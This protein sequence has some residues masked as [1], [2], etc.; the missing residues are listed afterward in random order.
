M[1]P[2]RS[3]LA[4]LSILLVGSCVC[5]GQSTNASIYGTVVDATGAVVTK[6]IVVATNTRTGIALSTMS[7]ESGVYIFGSL[8][9][10]EYTVSA[11][12]AGFRKAVSQQFQLA[13]SARI[14][15]D[16]KLEVG[17]ATES[18]TAESSSSLLETVNTSVSNVVSLR[19]V[20]DLPLTPWW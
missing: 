18:V 9:P 5:S 2:R 13:V 12:A 1:N 15:V 19:R 4:I 8:Q 6:S 14:T 11:E 20:Q 17:S 16:L 10:G 7:N 3:N